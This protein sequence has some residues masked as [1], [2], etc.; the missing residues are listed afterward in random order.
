MAFLDGPMSS[1][2]RTE[3][4]GLIITLMSPIP[5]HAALDSA[6]VL[7]PARRI[8][9]YLSNTTNLQELRARMPQYVVD[10]PRMPLTKQIPCMAKSDLWRIFLCTLVAR[11]P[12]S[13]KFKKTKGHA[14]ED[15]RFLGE[16]PELK[17]KAIMNNIADNVA[18]GARHHFHH[19][20]LVQ[21]ATVLER[22]HTQ[23]VKFVRAIQSTIGR[24]HLASQT[25]RKTPTHDGTS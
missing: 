16:H 4:L 22:G 6:A 18:D 20:K 17:K 25:I 7:F 11:G 13:V 23:N 9:A 15:K 19:P 12:A 1:P 2:S 3:L 24:V 10:V 21:L 8:L 5:V 14:I